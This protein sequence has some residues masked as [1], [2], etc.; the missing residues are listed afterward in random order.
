[1]TVINEMKIYAF[2]SILL[3]YMYFV[4]LEYYIIS[5]YS[6]YLFMSY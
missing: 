6:N 1:M 4:W 2:Q 3:F 5:V